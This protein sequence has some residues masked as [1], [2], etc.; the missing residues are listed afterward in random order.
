MKFGGDARRERCSSNERG[1]D[2]AIC[3][4]SPSLLIPILHSESM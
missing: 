1:G 3:N 2:D 4:I